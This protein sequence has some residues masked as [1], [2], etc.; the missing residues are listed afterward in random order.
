M[1][2]S[3]FEIIS[4]DKLDWKLLSYADAKYKKNGTVTYTAKLD[5]FCHQ[6]YKGDIIGVYGGPLFPGKFR[7][8]VIGETVK[9]L[10]RSTQ[11]KVLQSE[12]FSYKVGEVCSASNLFVAIAHVET[13]KHLKAFLKKL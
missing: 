11:F 5:P 13:N 4:A 6:S 7:V 2:K 9:G 8:R 3:F 12:D 10:K 1:E